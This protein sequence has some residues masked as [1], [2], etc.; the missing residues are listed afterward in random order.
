MPYCVTCGSEIGENDRFCINCGTKNNHFQSSTEKEGYYRRSPSP[1]VE[2]P[3]KEEVP[4]FIAAKE[5]VP[6][7]IAAKEYRTAGRPVYHSN[8]EN[9]QK[10]GIIIIGAVLVSIVVIGSLATGAFF[11]LREN[12]FFGFA[13]HSIGTTQASFPASGINTVQ[14]DISNTVGSVNIDVVD[15]YFLDGQ[16]FQAEIETFANHRYSGNTLGSYLVENQEDAVKVSFNSYEYPGEL[17]FAHDIIISENVAL[18]LV[19]TVTTGDINIDVP[20]GANLTA[21]QLVTTTGRINCELMDI[22]TAFQ[23][24]VIK[25]TTGSVDLNFGKID[26][27]VNISTWDVSATTGSIDIDFDISYQAITSTRTVIF[28]IYVTTGSI[29]VDFNGFS[30]S[31]PVGVKILDAYA[32]TGSTAIDSDLKPQSANYSSA[33][34]KIDVSLST[35]TGSIDVDAN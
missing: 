35:T 16:A 31:S 32:T 33:P 5:E 6:R 18:N 17:H 23:S 15:E 3:A 10:I 25:T 4:R 1:A 27:A 8:R 28:D 26:P 22:T 20:L 12:F 9:N 13:S 34:L 7:F 19:I 11:G 14:I 30:S 21:L 2:Q 29:E 24:A